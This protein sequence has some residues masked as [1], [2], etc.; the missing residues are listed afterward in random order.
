MT[1]K[2]RDR[3]CFFGSSFYHKMKID[4]PRKKNH[5][6][7]DDDGNYDEIVTL[8]LSYGSDGGCAPVAAQIL[9]SELAP[10]ICD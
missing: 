10:A 5:A 6:D 1:P 3:C 4:P 9:L 2:V 7:D 8:N